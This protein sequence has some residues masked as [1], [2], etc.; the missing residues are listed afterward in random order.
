MKKSQEKYKARHDQHKV[1]KSFE[2]E[3]RVW[4]SLNKKRLLGH[5]KNIKA[6]SYVPFEALEKVGDNIYRLILHTCMH[7]YSIVNVENMKLYETS[8]LD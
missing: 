3:D 2:V 8:M 7:I 6:L 4:L 5:G 1:K